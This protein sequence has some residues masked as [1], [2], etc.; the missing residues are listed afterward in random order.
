MDAASVSCM[1]V[2]M[3]FST[4]WSMAFKI[5]WGKLSLASKR[6]KADMAVYDCIFSWWAD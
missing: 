6:F 4:P 5:L 1:L 2:S 3:A